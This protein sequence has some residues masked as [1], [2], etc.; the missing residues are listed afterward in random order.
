MRGV[1]SEILLLVIL[2]PEFGILVFRDFTGSIF[3]FVFFFWLIQKVE[4]RCGFFTAF[5]GNLVLA[6][7]MVGNAKDHVMIQT[8]Q[9]NF[10][11]SGFASQ[12]FF[13][14]RLLESSISTQKIQN[15]KSRSY[16]HKNDIRKKQDRMP[17]EN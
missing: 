12:G 3:A 17:V 8:L 2:P 10:E 7:K 11:F 1:P 13:C 4:L 9:I 14:F 6:K 16:Q 5:V 15:A